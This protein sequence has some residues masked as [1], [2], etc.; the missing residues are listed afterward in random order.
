[1]HFPRPDAA[2]RRRFLDDH[3]QPELLGRLDVDQVVWQ[4]DGLSFAELDEVKKLLVLAYLDTGEWN[5]TIAWSAF[6][7]G[8]AEASCRAPIGF[9]PHSEPTSPLRIARA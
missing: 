2:L 5:W 1:M 6:N 3:W 8:R 7:Q 4:T 9:K